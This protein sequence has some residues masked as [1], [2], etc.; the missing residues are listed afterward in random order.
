[1]VSGLDE[2]IARC[3]IIGSTNL[4]ITSSNFPIFASTQNTL[5]MEGYTSKSGKP[6]GVVAYEIGDDYIL[7]RFHEGPPYKYSV[8]SA[9][10]DAVA[11]M[12]ELALNQQ[13]LSTYIARYKP[14]FE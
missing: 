4:L 1:M 12:K 13:G 11:K 10:H 6:S 9:G 8:T 2:F 5:I 3:L 14:A 7:V